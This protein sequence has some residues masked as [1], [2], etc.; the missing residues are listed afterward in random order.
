MLFTL[1][2]DYYIDYTIIIPDFRHEI[3]EKVL[4]LT[5]KVESSWKKIWPAG[6]N[7]QQSF[8]HVVSTM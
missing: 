4:K 2:V 1:V 3:T 7:S 8:S 6:W 5:K